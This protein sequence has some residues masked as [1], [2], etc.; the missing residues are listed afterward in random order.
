[1]KKANQGNTAH[2]SASNNQQSRVIMP[3]IPHQKVKHRCCDRNVPPCPTSLVFNLNRGQLTLGAPPPHW[4][5]RTQFLTSVRKNDPEF[6]WAQLAHC[7]CHSMLIHSC[8]KF[9]PCICEHKKHATNVA[10]FLI[11]DCPFPSHQQVTS[12]LRLDLH[13]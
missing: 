12:L 8:F 3:S 7:L 13:L 5:R 6:D 11:Y 4:V 1:M 10:A 9:E 2:Q